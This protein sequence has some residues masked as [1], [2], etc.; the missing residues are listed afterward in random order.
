MFNKGE[1]VMTTW[2]TE[3]RFALYSH[4]IDELA[5]HFGNN[6]TFAEI[7][8]QLKSQRPAQTTASD[9]SNIFV[10]IYDRLSN[11]SNL[12]PNN[13][14]ASSSAVQQQVQWCLTV[15]ATMKKGQL[16][17]QRRN[18]SAAY[19]AGFMSIADIVE[20]ELVANA[21]RKYQI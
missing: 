20:L 15:Q 1:L 10:K 8:W 19:E 2:S 13:L 4:L 5:L 12:F 16:V 21:R 3:S 9:W 18:R 17:N 11:K 14:P 6:G 7:D